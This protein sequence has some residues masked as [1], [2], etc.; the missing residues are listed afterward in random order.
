MCLCVSVCASAWDWL[1]SCILLFCSLSLPCL[2]CVQNLSDDPQRSSSYITAVPAYINAP[3]I[4]ILLDYPQPQQHR[5]IPV[6]W[7]IGVIPLQQQVVHKYAS[8][9][10]CC[11]YKGA[12]FFFYRQN[13]KICH[14]TEPPTSIFLWHIDIILLVR[15]P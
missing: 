8:T 6:G 5:Y 7:M 14:L 15:Q 11:L 12:V 10:A 3:Y 1:E 9:C 2:S 13:F 4:S